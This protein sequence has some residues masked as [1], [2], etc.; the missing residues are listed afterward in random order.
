M[1]FSKSTSTPISTD[2]ISSVALIGTKG[3]AASGGNSGL[4]YS[5]DSGVTWLR[6]NVTSLNFSYVVLSTDG[7]KG[8][9]ASASGNGLYYSTNSGQNWTRS[10]LTDGT[11]VITGSF[12]NI[13]LSGA[14]AIAA[15][16][17]DNIGIWYSANSGQTWTQSSNRTTGIFNSISLS[18]AN[19]IA[20][21]DASGPADGIW[22]SNDSGQTWTK[23]TL[24]T[25]GPTSN[26]FASVFLSGS[27]GIAGSLDGFG[28]YYTTTS[29]ATWTRSTLTTGGNTSGD[30]YSVFL[31]GTNG[32]AGSGTNN[33][34]IYYSTNSGQTWTPSNQTAGN[35]MVALSGGIGV[36]GSFDWTGPVATVGIFRST[37]NGINLVQTNQTTGNFNSVA[38]YNYTAIL[39][40]VSGEGVY[41]SLNTLC[42]EK[43]TLILVL[44]NEV[45]VYRKICELKVGDIVKTYK[46]GYKKITYIKSFMYNTTNITRLKRCMYKMIGHDVI[47]TGKHGILVDEVTEEELIRT[48]KCG[49]TIRHIDD[50]K[51][52]PACASDKFEKI[53][54]I[55]EFELWHFVLENDDKSHNYG[56][57]ITDGILS[58]SCS[59]NAFLNK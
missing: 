35:F 42:Y 28:I 13:S 40:S 27:N 9:A 58:E 39:G 33:A 16:N 57:Y 6:S 14:N 44:E 2:N 20:A 53:T 48:K 25:G 50:K 19:G 51:V 1:S 37:N 10:T 36:A 15:S 38:L 8:I 52:L 55:F 26:S 41:Y 47:V 30:F 34:G 59:E 31:S 43:N 21:G 46:H 18:G 4:Y 29:G 3:I 49:T 11:T 32:V 17:S 12:F 54:D 56:I 23:A 5:T 24:T 45:E 7:T 22:Y